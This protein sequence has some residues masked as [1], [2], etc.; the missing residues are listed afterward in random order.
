MQ[1]DKLKEL[2]KELGE[3]L[4]K[5]NCTLQV[6]HTIQVVPNKPM[7]EEVIVDGGTVEETAP[8]VAVEEAPAEEVA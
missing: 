7:E 5:F 3:L 2:N 8:E 6:A 4:A 1:E